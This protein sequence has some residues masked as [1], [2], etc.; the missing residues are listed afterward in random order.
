MEAWCGS[1]S[2]E[3]TSSRRQCLDLQ[4]ASPVTA[5]VAVGGQ[6]YQ[7]EGGLPLAGALRLCLQQPQGSSHGGRRTTGDGRTKFALGISEYDTFFAGN[8]KSM[9][10]DMLRSRPF[11]SECQ[12]QLLS[13]AVSELN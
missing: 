5:G 3:P 9:G 10:R 2:L 12:G 8:A 11:E 7:A 4:G 6:R 13:R 1:L